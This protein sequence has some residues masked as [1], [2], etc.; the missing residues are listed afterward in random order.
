MKLFSELN[1]R[2]LGEYFY[3]LAELSQDAFWI[4]YVNDVQLYISPAYEK[5]WGSSREKLYLDADSWFTAIHPDDRE[6]LREAINQVKNDPRSGKSYLHEYRIIRPDQTMRWIQ[7][8]GFP[9]FDTNDQLLGFAGVAKDITHERQRLAELEKATHFF[10]IFAEKIQQAV[11]WAWDP[12]CNK[13]IYVSPSYE[14]IWGRTRKSLYDDPMSWIQ[15]LIPE[16]RDSHSVETRLRSLS[17]HGSDAKYVDRYRIFN[18]EGKVICIKDTSFP[19]YDEQGKFMGFAGIAEDVTKE[20]IQEQE[21]REAKQRAEVANQAKSDFLAMVSHELRT[22]LNAI[23]GMAQIL[24]TKGLSVDLKEYVDIISNAGNN[25]LALVSDI[26]DFVK[27]EA[28]KLTFVRQPFNLQEL[29]MQVVHSMQYQAHDKS[30]ELL[31]DYPADI[32]SSV[33]GDQNRARQILV[34]LLSNAIKFTDKGYIHIQVKCKK[35]LKRKAVFEIVVIDTGIGI[36]KDKLGYIF[37]KFS[38]INSIYYRK[39]QGLGLGLTIAKE[40]VEKMGGKIEVKSECGKGSQFSFTLPLHLWDL[41]QT[42]TLI[43]INDDKLKLTPHPYPLK[44]LLVEDNIVNQK[45]A[46]VMLE[47]L[48]C[49]VEVIDNGHDVLKNLQ[50]LSRFDLIFMDVGL[51]DIS[52]FDIVSRLRQETNLKHMPIVAMTAHVL[53]R[54]RQQAYEAGMDKIIAKP[55][56]YDEIGMVLQEYQ[57]GR[58]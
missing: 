57:H 44:I 17:E 31:V 8:S 45:I 51:P 9:I 23:L 58:H 56:S 52:G 33:I 26:L 46:K 38:Q 54:D 12:H 36:R 1:P 48:G 49:C 55:I 34:N 16:D 47:D 2:S 41:T 15:T 3:K 6:Q 11:F 4:R 21:L 32:A 37:E 14:K 13:Q 35:K 7:E 27:L 43:K 28:G 10:R 24:Y 39:H 29:I 5:I 40:L 18:A 50:A 30:L 22:P 53:D 20:A 25:L 19:L 42:K